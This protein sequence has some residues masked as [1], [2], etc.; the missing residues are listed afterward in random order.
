MISKMKTKQRVNY[1][2]GSI[3]QACNFIK[4]RLQHRCFPAISTKILRKLILKN[5]CERLLLKIYPLLL[6]RF[7]EDISEVAVCHRSKKSAYAGALFQ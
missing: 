1:N 5:I 7:L 6:F 4:K 3:I 2:K